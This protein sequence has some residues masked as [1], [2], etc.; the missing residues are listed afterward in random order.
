[1]RRPKHLQ[2]DGEIYEMTGKTGSYFY[3]AP[4][5]ANEEGYNQKVGAPCVF[6]LAISCVHF[7]TPVC[8]RT[9]GSSKSLFFFARRRMCFH[10]ASSCMS[11]LSAQSLRSWLSGQQAT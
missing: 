7:A 5:V 10:L 2:G 6:S 1:M 4:E 8:R 9:L 11:S 3:M